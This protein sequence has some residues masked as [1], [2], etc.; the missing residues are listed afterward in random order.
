LRLGAGGL[1]IDALLT[2]ILHRLTLSSSTLHSLPR[3]EGR[4]AAIYMLRGGSPRTY[5]CLR[6]ISYSHSSAYAT[7]IIDDIAGGE[8]EFG[9]FLDWITEESGRSMYVD[10]GD[11]MG[12]DGI[13]RDYARRFGYGDG[14]LWRGGNVSLKRAVTGGTTDLYERV[15]Y[16]FRGNIIATQYPITTTLPH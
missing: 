8:R 16:D 7:Y 2:T 4:L 14:A 5:Y 3:M 15:W 13:G 10:H 11:I 12:I 6:R 9:D 1:Y